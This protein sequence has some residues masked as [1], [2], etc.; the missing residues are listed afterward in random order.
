MSGCHRGRTK[1]P[2]PAIL[3]PTCAGPEGRQG[4]H[5]AIKGLY[6][7]IPDRLPERRD[8]ILGMGI[9]ADYLQNIR[10]RCGGVS[11]G[12]PSLPATGKEQRQEQH[13][14]KPPIGDL[15]GES[16][17][18]GRIP[19]RDNPPCRLYHPCTL[20]RD[21]ILAYRWEPLWESSGPGF[22]ANCRI[23]VLPGGMSRKG[24]PACGSKNAMCRDRGSTRAEWDPGRPATVS[25]GEAT[26]SAFLPRTR[27]VEPDASERKAGKRWQVP[28][29]GW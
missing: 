1:G 28:G 13:R 9:G 12:I 24:F 19:S 26:R 22:G 10:Q 15:F 5:R 21:G 20:R 8:V 16:D 17:H 6:G 29:S 11:R 7:D 14:R 3:K 23:P 27:V 4:R 2:L 25:A 18:S